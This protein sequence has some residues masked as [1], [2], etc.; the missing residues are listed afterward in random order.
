MIEDDEDEVEVVFEADFDVDKQLVFMPGCFDDFE[1]T[2]EEL[3]ELIA[4]IKEAFRNGSAFENSVD[5]E[6][7]EFIIDPMDRSLQ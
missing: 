2:Q 4:N 5:L 6:E 1:G 7:E 3:D